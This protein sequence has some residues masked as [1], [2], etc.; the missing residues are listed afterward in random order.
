MM[1]RVAGMKR[2]GFVAVERGRRHLMR[3]VAARR[4]EK[5]LASG[6]KAH[7]GCGPVHLEGWVNVDIAR[8]VNPDVR[9]DLRGGF[10]APAASLAFV[11]SEHVFEHLTLADG[12]RLLRDCQRALKPG[13]VLR[14]AMPDLR[15]VV[16]RYLGDW[17]NQDWL[18]EPYYQQAVDSPAKMLNTSLRTWGHMYVYDLPEIT[19]RLREVG[20]CTVEPQAWGDSA[21]PEL[22][23][24]ERRPDSQL[25]VEA[26]A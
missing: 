3:Q 13:G 14:V 20:F 16:D 26:S 2:L 6:A 12:C 7:L 18:R 25:V 22:R 1:S 24:L 4:L 15:Y 11:Y 5:Y 8:E 9:I 21:H 17:R 19:L 23:G 10:P